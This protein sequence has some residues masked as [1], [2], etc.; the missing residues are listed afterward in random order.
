VRGATPRDV[1]RLT[2]ILPALIAGV[3]L[4]VE[5]ADPD[6]NPADTVAAGIPI[7]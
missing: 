1:E 3:P 2:T 7:A 4:R 5:L 6:R